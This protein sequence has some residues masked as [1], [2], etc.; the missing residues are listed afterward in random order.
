MTP[1]VSLFRKLIWTRF[2]IC[3]FHVLSLVHYLRIGVWQ[4]TVTKNVT[5][6]V[7]GGTKTPLEAP[8][9]SGRR[10][11]AAR[12]VEKLREL[13][14]DYERCLEAVRGTRRLWVMFRGWERHQEVLGGVRKLREL[15]ESYGRHSETLG[16]VQRLRE[17]LKEA[18]G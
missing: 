17:T 10:S 15:P 3:H 13:S 6:H 18:L 11:E 12:D 14:G 9:D 4:K 2:G 5:L 7:T 1:L 8:T 16:G